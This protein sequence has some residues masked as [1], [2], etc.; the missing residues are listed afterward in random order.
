MGVLAMLSIF[1]VPTP[2][3]LPGHDLDSPRSIVDVPRVSDPFPHLDS[4][5]YY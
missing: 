5:Y 2:M 1:Q 3:F 4:D